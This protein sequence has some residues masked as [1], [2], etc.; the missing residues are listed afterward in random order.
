MTLV[1][2]A[3]SASIMLGMQVLKVLILHYNQ[4]HYQNTNT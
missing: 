1:S 4:H 2:L 3:Y